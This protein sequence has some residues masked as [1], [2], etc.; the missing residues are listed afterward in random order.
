MDA[1]QVPKTSMALLDSVL[2]VWLFAD[3]VGVDK[4]PL[5]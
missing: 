1:S 2:P 3:Q 4:V 5:P